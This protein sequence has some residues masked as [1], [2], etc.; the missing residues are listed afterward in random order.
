MQRDR[1]S[2]GLPLTA[3]AGKGAHLLCLRA[4]LRYISIG[5]T[6]RSIMS[7]M[8]LGTGLDND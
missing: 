5:M 4:G 3:V 8:I 2:E 6:I 1:A 7:Q